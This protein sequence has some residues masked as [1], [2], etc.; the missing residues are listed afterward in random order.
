[1]DFIFGLI[2]IYLISSEEFYNYIYFYLGRR[3]RQFMY[4]FEIFVKSL[5]NIS[6]YDQNIVYELQFIEVILVGESIEEEEEDNDDVI[7]IDQGGLSN[8]F[9]DFFEMDLLF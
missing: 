3:I 2:K 9:I 1:M 7:I 6:V 5:Y 4:E 8:D